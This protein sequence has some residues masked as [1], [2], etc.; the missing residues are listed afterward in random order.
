[1]K[2]I[3][4][5]NIRISPTLHGWLKKR[6]AEREKPMTVYVR[7]LLMDQMERDPAYKIERER[8]AREEA[9]MHP[10][11]KLPILPGWKRTK[12]IHMDDSVTYE[13]TNK[14]TG[15]CLPAEEYAAMIGQKTEPLPPPPVEKPKHLPMPRDPRGR[16]LH[17]AL[18]KH[19]EEVRRRIEPLDQIEADKILDHIGYV[20]DE[21]HKGNYDTV[22]AFVGG[23]YD[24]LITAVFNRLTGLDASE[25]D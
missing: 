22:E 17:R 25:D 12:Y 1:M 8:K 7:D 5:L 18:E 24:N 20:R 15:E 21:L 6:A 23:Y 10:H 11:E 14:A 13:F 9:N 16:R 19:A 3:R 4:Y 2:D